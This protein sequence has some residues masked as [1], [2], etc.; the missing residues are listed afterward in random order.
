MLLLGTTDT[1]YDGDPGAVTATDAD[2]DQVLAEAAVALEPELLARERVRY[3]LA[4]LRVLPGAAADTVSARREVELLHGPTGMLSVAGGKLTTHRRIALRVL[5]H[6][7]AFR[8]V[9]LS[10][11][12]LPGSGPLPPRPREVEPALWEHLVHL[13]GSETPA[14]LAGEPGERVHP[15]GPDVWAQVVHAVE[16]EWALTVEDVV[17]RRTTLQVRGLATPE[18]RQA[19]AATLTRA[20]VLKAADGS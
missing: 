6:L 2:V 20:G 8:N 5:Q 19:V 17:R 13:Y 1:L 11:D 10:S 14:L 3:T 7:E 18:V 16:H 4:G 12:P 15:D 9:R